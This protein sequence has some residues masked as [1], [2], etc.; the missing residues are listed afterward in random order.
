M[1]LPGESPAKAVVNLEAG[2]RYLKRHGQYIFIPGRHRD[3]GAHSAKIRYHPQI[4]RVS[5]HCLQGGPDASRD[6]PIRRLQRFAEGAPRQRLKA[7]S[8]VNHAY[9]AIDSGDDRET[10]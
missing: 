6:C 5:P 2:G 10:E 9:V 4:N 8:N 3:T 1:V 7:E